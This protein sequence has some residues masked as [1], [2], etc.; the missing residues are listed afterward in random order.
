M[1]GRQSRRISETV[2]LAGQPGVYVRRGSVGDQGDGTREREPLVDRAALINEGYRASMFRHPA[3]PPTYEDSER[4]RSP[5][6]SI[7]SV[8]VVSC[9]PALS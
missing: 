2:S 1:N 3:P 7:A 5:P 9:N 8:E 6:L 4:G